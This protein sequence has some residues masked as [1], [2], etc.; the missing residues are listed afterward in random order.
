MKRLQYGPNGNADLVGQIDPALPRKTPEELE[1]EA[2][3]LVAAQNLALDLDQLTAQH[4]N[5]DARVYFFR[6]EDRSNRVDGMPAFI[7]VGLSAAGD[8]VSYTNLLLLPLLE[9]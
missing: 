4:G 7:Q 8:L 2:R 1:T 5:K 3:A 6:W 9:R